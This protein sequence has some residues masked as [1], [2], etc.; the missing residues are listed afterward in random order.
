MPGAGDPGF[1]LNE[2]KKELGYGLIVFLA[3]YSLSRTRREVATW[4]MVILCNLLWLGIY[5]LW[6]GLSSGTLAFDGWHGGE[7][8]YSVFV[9]TTFPLLLAA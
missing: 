5:T 6:Q 9:A 1:S 2:I 3:F 7:L 4:M 8:N